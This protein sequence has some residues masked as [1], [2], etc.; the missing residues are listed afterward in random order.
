VTIHVVFTIK[1]K[2]KLNE[3]EKKARL[4]LVRDR[5]KKRFYW[6]IPEKAR[7]RVRQTKQKTIHT[8]I[9]CII[10]SSILC[11]KNIVRANH[12][13]NNQYLYSKYVTPYFF[14]RKRKKNTSI[15][16]SPNICLFCRVVD[17]LVGQEKKQTKKQTTIKI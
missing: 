6:Y 9:Q 16:N 15:M 1:K 5:I 10:Y 2:K 13:R 7:E 14:Y 12:L 3:T 8:H 17:R 4:C 11:I